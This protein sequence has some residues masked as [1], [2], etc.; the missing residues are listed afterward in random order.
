[1]RWSR[2]LLVPHVIRLSLQAPRDT[3]ARWDRYWADVRAT[4]DEGDVLWDSSS[5]GEAQRYLDLLGE[6]GDATL[7]VVDVGCGNGRF[8]RALA[9]RFTC[10]IGVD[11]APHAVARARD[12]AGSAPGDRPEFR[13]ADMTAPGAGAALAAELGPCNV[14]IRGVLHAMPGPA[15]RA[16]AANVGDLAGARGTVLVAETNHPGPL[17][18]YLE[19]LGG[20]PRGLP[21]PLARALSAGLPRPGP[22]GDPELDDAFPGTT[23]NRVLT[24]PHNTIATIPMQRGDPGRTIAGH[25]VVLRPC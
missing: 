6:H 5:S 18:G 22:C 1:M 9:T 20:G 13:V 12:E 3:S 16:L 2:A 24:D 11:L 17:L 25:L 4:G 8:T 7:P 19:H 14:F 15:R 21:R 10:A 23:W